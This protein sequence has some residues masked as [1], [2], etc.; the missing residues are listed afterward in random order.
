MKISS[1]PG[2]AA[3]MI[4][5]FIQQAEKNVGK[6]G[7][8]KAARYEKGPSVAYVATIQEYGSPQNNIPPRPF[9]RPTIEVQQN[10]WKGIAI[11]GATAIFK[12]SQTPDSVLNLIG[13]KASGD[14]KATIRFIVAVFFRDANNSSQVKKTSR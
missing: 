12:G 7:W 8:F 13:A 14:M 1:V 4:K 10:K 5:K 3:A 2:P 9:M 6:V 11:Q